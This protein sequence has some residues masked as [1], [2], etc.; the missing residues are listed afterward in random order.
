MTWRCCVCQ[1]EKTISAVLDYDSDCEMVTY[2]LCH[3]C[4]EKA[5]RDI[6]A[7][8]RLQSGSLSE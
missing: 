5:L 3:E 6:E 8:E 4:Y 2:G 1:K 7:F